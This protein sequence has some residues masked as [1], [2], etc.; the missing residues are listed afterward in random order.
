[1]LLKLKYL[2]PFQFHIDHGP[3]LGRRL[4]ETLV[5]FSDRRCA[6]VGPLTSGVSVMNIQAET[7]TRSGTRPFQ[8]LKVT[9]GVAE[10]CDGPPA[11]EFLNADWLAGAVIHKIHSGKFDDGWFSVTNLEF[12]FSHAATTCSGGMP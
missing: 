11:N 9:I 4:V 8:H 6:V 7:R 1:L 3:A 12:L 10:S 2:L 5:E